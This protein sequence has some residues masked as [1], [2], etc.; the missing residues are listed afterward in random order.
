MKK[1]LGETKQKGFIAETWGFLLVALII[2]LGVILLFLFVWRCE[3]QRMLGN[4]IINASAIIFLAFITLSYALYTKKLSDQ[5]KAQLKQFALSLDEQVRKTRADFNERRIS[6]FY[7][8]FFGLLYEMNSALLEK[9]IDEGLTM[10]IIRRLNSLFVEKGYMISTITRQKLKLIDPLFFSA[11]VS[12]ANR[13]S[14]IKKFKKEEDEIST[15][16]ILEWDHIENEI[17]DFYDIEWESVE[18]IE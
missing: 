3:E 14:M 17:R 11:Q 7:R 16:L 8:P 6:K 4:I 12:L 2:I 1:N 10:S 15:I 9:E 13:E 18:N 5:G